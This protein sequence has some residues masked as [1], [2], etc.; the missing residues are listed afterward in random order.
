LP[1]RT[2]GRTAR[3]PAGAPWPAIRVD[4]WRSPALAADGL[5]EL[6]A[7]T[8]SARSAEP[9][10]ALTR[11]FLAAQDTDAAALRASTAVAVLLGWLVG[12]REHVADAEAGADPALGPG[13][14]DWVRANLGADESGQA[15]IL[16]GALDHPLAPQL[17]MADAVERLGDALLPAL[18][19]L[20]AGLTA[21]AGDGD[22]GWLG[23]FEP[24]QDRPPEPGAG[25]HRARKAP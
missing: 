11:A 15:L 3:V 20:V 18:L 23:R 22:T 17:T 12:A 7:A 4:D 9:G 19:W 10:R 21:T 16:A 1:V 8:V 25:R 24:S 13:A 14:V 5:R 2:K 6:I